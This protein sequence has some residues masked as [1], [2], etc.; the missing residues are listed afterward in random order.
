[1]SIFQKDDQIP[2]RSVVAHLPLQADGRAIHTSTI[3]RWCLYGLGGVKLA[4]TKIGGRRYVRTA[5]LA[6]FL[7][8]CTGR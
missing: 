4:S 2:I 3:V 1:M 6:R 5:D 8:E 7:E